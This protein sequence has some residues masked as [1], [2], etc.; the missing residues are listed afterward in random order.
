MRKIF[1]MFF[2]PI[3][4][5]AAQTAY[6]NGGNLVLNTGGTVS[7]IQFNLTGATAAPVI[8][9]TLAASKS[10][11]CGPS[12]ATCL[13][14]GNNT[15]TIPDGN[16]VAIPTGASISNF[17]ASSPTGTAIAVALVSNPCDVNHDGKIDVNDFSAIVQQ[18]DGAVTA[19]ADINGDGKTDIFD[20]FRVI[21]AIANG[22][23]CKVGP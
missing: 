12:F 21:L 15:T 8:N 4:A 18:A 2:L 14:V 1:S 20:V 23:V 5:L 11:F 10:V 19:S 22:G 9:T 17:I 6:V 13:V 16:V 3:V 7:A